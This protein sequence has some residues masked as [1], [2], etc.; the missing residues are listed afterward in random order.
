MKSWFNSVNHTQVCAP[1]VRAEPHRVARSASALAESGAGRPAQLVRERGLT[2]RS[3]GAPTA[4]HQARAGGTPHI[5]TGPSLAPCR[6]HPLS[7]NVRRPNKPPC[8][9]S[10]REEILSRSLEVTGA[11]HTATQSNFLDP[12][13]RVR[14]KNL[15]LLD[16]QGMNMTK[17][18]GGGGGGGRSGGGGSGGGGGKGGGGGGGGGG[19]SGGRSGSGGG[20]PST[21]GNTSGGGRTNAPQSTPTPSSTPTK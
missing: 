11:R 17:G 21:T 9:R 6:R 8:G 16:E 4:G 20:W 18:S 14:S 1:L 10:Q 13:A 7:S 15:R 5:F 2:P 19:G 12:G 3:S